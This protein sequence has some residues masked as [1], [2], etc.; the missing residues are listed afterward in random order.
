MQILATLTVT[1]AS[2]ERSFSN[3]RALKTYLRNT[4]KEDRLSC[5]AL[6]YIHQGIDLPVSK[7]IQDFAAKKARRLQIALWCCWLYEIHFCCRVLLPTRKPC[8]F[9]CVILKVHN[10]PFKFFKYKISLMFRDWRENLI[11]ILWRMKEV[12]RF[13]D[14]LSRDICILARTS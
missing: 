2:A 13:L 11:C 4:I 10:L 14:I 8:F 7:I 3:L 9:H 6:M 12:P 5:L 1:K